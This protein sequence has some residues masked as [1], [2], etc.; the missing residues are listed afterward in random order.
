MMK[1]AEIIGELHLSSKPIE[2]WKVS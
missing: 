2:G 1:T